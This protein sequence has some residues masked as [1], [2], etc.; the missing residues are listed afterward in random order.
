VS[1]TRPDILRR[2]PTTPRVEPKRRQAESD[3][4]AVA[5]DAIAWRGTYPF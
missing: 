3:P 4:V 2:K 1:R 5:L